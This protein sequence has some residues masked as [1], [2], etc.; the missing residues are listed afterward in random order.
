[1]TVLMSLKSHG[2]HIPIGLPNYYARAAC[3]RQEYDI[4]ILFTSVTFSVALHDLQM[5]VTHSEI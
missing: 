3:I 4:I 1:M 5:D 2:P